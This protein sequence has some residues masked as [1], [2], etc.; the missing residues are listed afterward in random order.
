MAC[1]GWPQYFLIYCNI[2]LH[3]WQEKETRISTLL[4]KLLPVAQLKE[5]INVR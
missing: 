2:V 5:E 4:Q 3:F 1:T